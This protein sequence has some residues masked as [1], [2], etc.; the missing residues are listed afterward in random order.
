MLHFILGLPWIFLYKIL[1]FN[2]PGFTSA[3]INEINSCVGVFETFLFYIP[4]YINLFILIKIW[5]TI[6]KYLKK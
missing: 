6:L 4:I 1:P 5:S 2:I 3:P